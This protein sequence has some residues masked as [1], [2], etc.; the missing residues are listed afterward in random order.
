[1]IDN[2]NLIFPLLDFSNED[3]FYHIQV[4]KRKKENPELGSNNSTIKHYYVNNLKYLENKFSEMCIITKSCNAR[5]CINL[6]RRSFEK[7]A[8]HTMKKLSDQMMNRDFLN[9]NKAYPRVCGQYSA[10]PSKKWILDIDQKD[11]AT[12]EYVHLIDALRAV[13]AISHS[14]IPTKNGEHWITSPFNL[15]DFKKQ[16]KGNILESIHKDNPTIL[17]IP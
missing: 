1:M 10:E 2:S 14:T 13:S 5:L 11:Y 3:L 7:L 4:I 16:Y 8:F 6:N 12:S 17:Y 9:I 15:M